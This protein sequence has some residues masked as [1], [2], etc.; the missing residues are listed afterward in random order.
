MPS[1]KGTLRCY[2]LHACDSLV[3]KSENPE[4]SMWSYTTSV[5]ATDSKGCV[6]SE[7]CV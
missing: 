7:G 4:L 5:E 3:M 1:I 2:L 6:N